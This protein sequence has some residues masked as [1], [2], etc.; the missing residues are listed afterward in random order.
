MGVL[1]Y[2]ERE[3]GQLFALNK[4]RGLDTQQLELDFSEFARIK[5]YA[6]DG[7]QA[8]DRWEWKFA[9]IRWEWVREVFVRLV[10][11]TDGQKVRLVDD[12]SYDPPEGK[13]KRELITG[14]AY[15]DD[16]YPD[17]TYKPGSAW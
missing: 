1:F 9:G 13:N 4:A 17:G 14:S 16:Y 3:D 15:A 10:Q 2:F 8:A 5:D 6:Q 7:Q 12:G 11:W